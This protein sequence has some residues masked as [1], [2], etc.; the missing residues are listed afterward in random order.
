MYSTEWNPYYVRRRP[1]ER[2]QTQPTPFEEEYWITVDPDGAKRNLLEERARRLE[3]VVE[4]LSYVNSLPPGRIL[5]VGCGLG[6]FLSAVDAKWE[7][8]GVELSQFAAAHAQQFAHVHNGDLQSAGYP[9]NHFDVIMLY[10]VIEH[11]NDPVTEIEEMFRVLKPGGSLI[12]GCPNFDSACA[13]R[14]GEKYR[15]L[16]D[17]THI[18]LFSRESLDRFLW[19]HGFFV[20]R[21]EFPYFETQHF[22]TENFERLKDTNNISPP[23][24]GNIM[25]FY[26]RKPVRSELLGGLAMASRLAHR[27]SVEQADQLEQAAALLLALSLS[28]GRLWTVGDGAP[29][30]AARFSVSGFNARTC[31][32][33]DTLPSEFTSDDVLFVT[34]SDAVP[35]ELMRAARQ[36]DGQ[37]IALVGRRTPVGERA[38]IV[39]IPSVDAR[40]I[41]YVQQFITTMLC[42]TLPSAD[43]ELSAP[44]QPHR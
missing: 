10:H 32:T 31:E 40:H 41:E 44:S 42:A 8:H 37:T 20:D 16:S 19:D 12:I 39:R 18:T 5:D 30:L 29:E 9:D 13:R 17:P 43:E 21:V 22:T 6:Y 26:C 14:F 2:S 11:M 35:L 15:M 33:V 1:P 28:Q 38:I 24:Y 4:E 7:K 36:R 3:D 27:V 34:A 25:T 23:F